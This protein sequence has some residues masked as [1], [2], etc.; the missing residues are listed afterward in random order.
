MRLSKESAI[1]TIASNL[2]NIGGSCLHPEWAA[3]PA[4]GD[5]ALMENM[6]GSALLP[7]TRNLQLL[8]TCRGP[9]TKHTYREVCIEVVL[10]VK[11]GLLV[12]VAVQGQ[13]CHHCRLYAPPVENLWKHDT[14]L[15]SDPQSETNASPTH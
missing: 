3:L 12:Y 13:A 2:V 15:L 5:R 9:A 4:E 7:G 8:R 6:R 14:Q 10:P 11:Q 1:R